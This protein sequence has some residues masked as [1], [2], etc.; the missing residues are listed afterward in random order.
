[1]VDPPAIE[2]RP[3][4]K[5]AAQQAGTRSGMECRHD[6]EQ[7]G[8]AEPPARNRLD[9]LS[10][11]LLAAA[12]ILRDRVPDNGECREMLQRAE[13]HDRISRSPEGP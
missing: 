2:R 7:Y 1:M 9:R 6:L 12:M 11:G 5:P 3:D 10:E 4:R 8:S 13:D